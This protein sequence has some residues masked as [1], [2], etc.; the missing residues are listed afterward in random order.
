MKNL[1]KKSKFTFRPIGLA[2]GLAF[3]GTHVQ[4]QFLSNSTTAPT[5][6]TLVTGTTSSK[7]GIG[8][9]SGTSLTDM[10]SLSAGVF[11]IVGSSSPY[12]DPTA[13]TGA[14]TLRMGAYNLSTD[15][16]KNYS[17]VQSYSTTATTYSPLLLNPKGAP[18]IIGTTSVGDLNTPL[19]VSSSTFPCIGIG[20]T[21]TYGGSVSLSVAT[22]NGMWSNASNA[23]DVVL[24]AASNNKKLLFT[25]NWNA[26]SNGYVDA[27]DFA[28][29]YQDT[30]EKVRMRIFANGAVAIGELGNANEFPTGTNFNT[31]YKYKLYVASG[32][33]T[34]KVRCAIPNSSFWAD[35]VFDKG[36]KLQ[37]LSEVEE[38]IQKNKHLPNVPSAAE[39]AKEGV[40]LVG[41]DVKLLEKI[42]ELTLHAIKQQKDIDELKK[43]NEQLL[44]KLGK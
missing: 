19:Q 44:K 4:A 6:A 28:T 18:V 16:T 42:E 20:S 30:D 43:Q 37:N 26:A 12:A 23:G 35:Y 13:S 3:A 22:G 17:W 33:M 10:L 31:T 27:I 25:N 1:F 15:A 38:Y 40:D 34:P 21:S 14:A 7:I 2:I 32:I 29:G 5:S 36:Y 41:M 11:R 39:V 8:Y 24:R 9:A